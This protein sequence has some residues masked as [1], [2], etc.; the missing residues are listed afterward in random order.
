MAQP[1][2]PLLQQMLLEFQN[3]R[4]D[5]AERIAQSI[6]RIN[7]KDGVALQ[8]LGLVLAMQSRFLEAVAPLSKAASLDSKDPE[9]LANLA[10]AQYSAKLYFEA[11]QT[12]E[13]LNRFIPNN[14]QILLD[15]GTAHAKLRQYEQAAFCYD[16][17]IELSPDY[18]LAWSNRG[19]LLADLG[20]PAKAIECYET[21]LQFNPSYPETWTNYGN[22]LYDLGRLEEARLA[23]EKALTID[24]NYGEAWSNHGNVLLDLKLVDEAFISY[25]KAYSILPELPLLKGQLINFYGSLCDWRDRDALVEVVLHE[26]SQAKPACHPFALLQTSASPSDQKQNAEIFTKF[27]IP[28][29]ND[30]LPKPV[31]LAK[32]DKI[33]IGYFSTDFMDHPVGMLMENLLRLHNRSQF[34]IYGFFLNKKVGDATEQRLT[35]L[36]DKSFDLF[37]INDAD[38][39]KLSIEQNLDIAIDLNGHTSGARMGIFARKIAPIQICY[40]G[41]AGTTGADFYQYLIADRIAIPPEDQKFYSEQIA[42]L[43]NSFF[44]ADTLIAREDFGVLPSR[45]SQGLPE[46]GFVFSCFNNSYKI[47]P[48]IFDIWMNLLNAVPESILWLSKPSDGAMENLKKEAL[49]RGVDSS[50]LIFAIREPTR[51]GH[52]SRLRLADLFLD[53]AF[54]NAHTTAADAL[55]A[56]VPVLTIRGN[57]FASRVASSM[58]TALDMDEMIVNSKEGYFNKA[59]DLATHQDKITQVKEKQEVNRS[60]TAL[61]DTKQYVK[62]IEDL[63]SNAVNKQL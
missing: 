38:A 48:D 27:R 55:W 47:T 17:V 44:P 2:A 1:Y 11:T 40:L 8:V 30:E 7:P 59:L 41:F 53:T 60:N 36:F 34:E 3:Q 16:K 23:H 50:R 54:F 61:F 63:Y 6:L 26:I 33:R 18:F 10:R 46:S 49:A 58:L 4:H 57:T 32:K 22:A 35:Q 19:N 12:F 9:L 42:Y 20:F 5:S 45:L 24:P 31:P 43:P 21:A 29:L 62:D 13:K 39:Q 25:K 14:P 37:G 28:I 15:K 56:G 51:K 52:L